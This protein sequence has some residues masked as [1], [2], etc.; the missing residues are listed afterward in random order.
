[1]NPSTSA[2]G[3]GW[4]R[5]PWRTGGVALRWASAENR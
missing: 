3:T 5:T 2:M 4:E 1:M